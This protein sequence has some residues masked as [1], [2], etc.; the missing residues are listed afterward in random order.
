MTLSMLDLH[1][2][3]GKTYKNTDEIATDFRTM[4]AHKM[5]LN[6][7]AGDPEEY[8]AIEQFLTKFDN[9]WKGLEGQNLVKGPETPPSYKN[10]AKQKEA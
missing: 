9:E 4:I 5:M 8:S 7:I 6:Q 3:I 2:K 10:P 1:I